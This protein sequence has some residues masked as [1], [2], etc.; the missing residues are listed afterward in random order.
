MNNKLVF[1][2]MFVVVASVATGFVRAQA[3][4]QVTTITGSSDQ[5]T[6]YFGIP[7]SEWKID[8][9]YTPD[10]Q[11][12]QYSSL[13]ITIYSESGAYIDQISSS[14]GQ[15]SG[16]NFEHNTIPGNYYLKIGDANIPSYSISISAEAISPTTTAT[17]IIYQTPKGQ[18]NGWQQIKQI[19]GSSDQTSDYFA[20]PNNE[21]RIDWS[22]T[23]DAQYP[24]YSSLYATI[25][26]KDGTYIDQISSTSSQTSGTFYVHNTVPGEYYLKIGAANIPSYSFDISAEP[27]SSTN[28]LAPSTPEYPIIGLIAGTLVIATLALVIVKKK[29]TV[30]KK[31]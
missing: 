16:T 11:Y 13:Y 26:A 21:W 6:S 9:S 17:P 1:A 19:I 5:T 8:W 30:S 28:T 20:I 12:P 10:A 27:A 24:Q 18:E 22:F 3:Y 4:N 31:L 25:Y 23:P 14:S 2:I 7:S 15:T 29:G